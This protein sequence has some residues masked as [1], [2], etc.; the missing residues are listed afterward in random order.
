MSDTEQDQ[1]EPEF[2][3]KAKALGE[4]QLM[5]NDL[6]PMPS[7]HYSA[8]GVPEEKNIKLAY[9]GM[10]PVVV[11]TYLRK[12]NA[13]WKEA[14]PDLRKEVIE[15]EQFKVL[16]YWVRYT[17][18]ICHIPHKTSKGYINTVQREFIRL[19]FH[20]NAIG[21]DRSEPTLYWCQLGQIDT[22]VK[23]AKSLQSN[24]SIFPD[25]ETYTRFWRT[26]SECRD[27]LRTSH[28]Y[29][30]DILDF[31][32]VTSLKSITE[33]QHDKHVNKKRAAR[34]PLVS[35]DEEE[36]K[37]ISPYLDIRKKVDSTHPRV[38]REYLKGNEAKEPGL[39]P[40]SFKREV[41]LESQQ[42]T[43]WHE[44]LHKNAPILDAKESTNMFAYTQVVPPGGQKILEQWDWEHRSEVSEIMVSES[45]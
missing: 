6:Q 32:D 43:L 31:Q 44:F 16:D 39:A 9:N 7:E 25:Q 8:W 21:F 13:D 41:F 19:C 11:D 2:K 22:L 28:W 5:H 20:L 27:Y 45:L 14:S 34:E 36:E 3:Y 26:V 40:S 12:L 42:R 33:E 10:F 17:A 1:A 29:S 38:F 15:P 24:P 37:R 35:D 18:P 23:A 4:G 30:P